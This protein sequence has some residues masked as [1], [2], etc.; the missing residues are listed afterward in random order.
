MDFVVNGKTQEANGCKT[1]VAVKAENNVNENTGVTTKAAAVIFSGASTFETAVE[2]ELVTAVGVSIII[3]LN[4]NCAN[5]LEV[6]SLV[7]ERFEFYK[8]WVIV[9]V[10]NK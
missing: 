9:G 2:A 4:I 10:T 7:V 5:K 6:Y 3:K 1:N 8:M